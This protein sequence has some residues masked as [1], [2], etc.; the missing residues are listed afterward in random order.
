VIT[1]TS[2]SE[3]VRDCEKTSLTRSASGPADSEDLKLNSYKL[4]TPQPE[5]SGAALVTSLY[6]RYLPLIR[7][8]QGDVLGEV[9]WLPHGHVTKFEKLHGRLNDMVE[10][11]DGTTIHSLAVAHC[12]RVEPSVLNIQMVLEDSGPKI[13]LVTRDGYNVEM[14]MRIRNRLKQIAPS[15]G[16]TPIEYV[17]DVETTRAGK[18][19]WA[20]DR[21]TSAGKER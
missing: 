6:R 21:R 8:R 20:L 15:L 19:R 4:K 10:L 1:N 14:E 12:I 9:Q 3:L 2:I 18:R 7:Y 5:A 11:S 17:A 13:L 16:E